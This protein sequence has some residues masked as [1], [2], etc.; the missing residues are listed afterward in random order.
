MTLSIRTLSIT[1]ISITILIITLFLCQL[2]HFYCYAGSYY[3]EYRNVVDMFDVFA[4]IVV[5]QSGI[6]QSAVRLRVEA[7]PNLGM[8]NLQWAVIKMYRAQSLEVVSGKP[9]KAKG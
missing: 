2:P 6:R 9:Y 5:M 8:T 7:P 4:R 1:T 3:A